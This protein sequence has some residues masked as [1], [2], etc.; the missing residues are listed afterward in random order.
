MRVRGHICAYLFKYDTIYQC[1][2]TGTGSYQ[3]PCSYL[4]LRARVAKN[5]FL[6]NLDSVLKLDEGNAIKELT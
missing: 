4:I 5:N 6:A 3:F 2:F 1:C